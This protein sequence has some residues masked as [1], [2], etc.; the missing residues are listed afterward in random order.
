[1]LLIALLVT[2]VKNDYPI[3]E[4]I[5]IDD[6]QRI[7]R[8]RSSTGCSRNME[9]YIGEG[10]RASSGMDWE[11]LCPLPGRSEIQG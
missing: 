10:Q 5:V 7:T 1:M 4:I 2:L 11:T 3:S 6:G 8:Q 9:S